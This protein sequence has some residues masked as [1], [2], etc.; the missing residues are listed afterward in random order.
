MTKRVTKTFLL[1]ALF[2]NFMST[3]VYA[4]DFSGIITYSISSK[5]NPIIKKNLMESGATEEQIM[6]YKNLY[7]IPSSIDTLYQAHNDGFVRETWNNDSLG[8]N[9]WSIYSPEDKLSYEF[10]KSGDTTICRANNFS[11]D[12]YS[13]NR[14]WLDEPE[15]KLIDTTVTFNNFSLSVIQIKWDESLYINYYYDKAHLQINPNNY[16]GYMYKGFYTFLQLSSSLPI[17]I[18]EYFRE[19]SIRSVLISES[20]LGQNAS[21]MFNVPEMKYDEERNGQKDSE[22]NLLRDYYKLDEYTWFMKII[23]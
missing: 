2:I 13:D 10:F 16:S 14:I 19:Y 1:L 18:E 5:L 9:Y 6:E 22:L 17:I 11:K 8:Q 23:N 4:Q 15:V 21:D 7:G 20:L 3:R 12:L